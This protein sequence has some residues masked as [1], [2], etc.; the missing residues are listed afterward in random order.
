MKKKRKILKKFE[1]NTNKRTKTEKMEKVN[2]KIVPTLKKRDEQ[3]NRHSHSHT[4]TPVTHTAHISTPN[5]P[6][7][8]PHNGGL[9]HAQLPNH[10]MFRMVDV[11]V[12]S[13]HLPLLRVAI[14]VMGRGREGEREDG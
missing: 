10:L 12:Q 9:S 1:K 14:E 13:P 11:S 8:A 3:I 6:L 7:S 5:D 4:H 2:G